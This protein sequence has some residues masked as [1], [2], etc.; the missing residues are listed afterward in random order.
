MTDYHTWP[1]KLFWV[2]NHFGGQARIFLIHR[3]KSGF[4]TTNIELQKNNSNDNGNNTMSNEKTKFK[5]PRWEHLKTW[6][7][8]F[9]VR[10]FRVGVFLIP[11][12]INEM[13]VNPDKFQAIVVKKNCRFLC[14]K[15]RKT[16][17]NWNRQCNMF[18]P[19][20]F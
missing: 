10:I 6:V 20:Y 9:Q 12:K 13:I 5:K 16:A 11:F 2:C 19:T 4:S 8:I 17:W 7:G 14:I 3:N 15:L 18:W 1:A